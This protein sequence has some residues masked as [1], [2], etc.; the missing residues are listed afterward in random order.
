MGDEKSEKTRN[1]YGIKGPKD[2]PDPVMAREQ[3]EAEAATAGIL[4]TLAG[5]QGSFN[6][7][8][9]PYGADYA[10]GTDPMSALG[11]MT[12][13]DIGQNFG[14]GG[15]G[16]RGTGRGGG[17]TGQ[18][19]IGL[20]NFGTIGRGGGKGDGQGGYGRGVGRLGGRSARVPKVRGGGANV[21]GALSKEVIRRVVR[22]HL[23]EVKF[24][25]E[26]QLNARPDLQ[27]RVTTKFVISPTGSVQSAVVSDSSLRNQ[28]VESCITRAVRRWTFPAPEGGGIVVVNYPFLLDAAGQ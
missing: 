16:L 11:A 14:F 23:N 15:L 1:K 25:Y 21:F 13:T 27:G 17:G 28:A 22:R 6:A 2:N 24:C 7:P 20:G 10:L 3:A 5:M 12:G 19:T 9:S 26:Q 8:T 18:G 4:G